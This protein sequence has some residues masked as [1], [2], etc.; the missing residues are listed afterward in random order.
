MDRYEKI[1]NYFK[2]PMDWCPIF[3]KTLLHLSCLGE[4]CGHVSIGNIVGNG[5]GKTLEFQGK[6][7][8]DY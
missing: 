5:S 6:V 8:R 7:E 4:D 2:D 1:L 3:L